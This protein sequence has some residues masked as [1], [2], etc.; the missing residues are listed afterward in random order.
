MGLLTEPECTDFSP[1]A[2]AAPRPL[3]S[4][5][6]R[7]KKDRAGPSLVFPNLTNGHSTSSKGEDESPVCS[8]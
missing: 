8:D 7:G 1:E 5:I 3:G 2:K 4:S 6:S